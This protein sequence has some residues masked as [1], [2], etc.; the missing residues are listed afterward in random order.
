MLDSLLV[1]FAIFALGFLARGSALIGIDAE[2]PLNDFVYYVSMPCLIM[3]N[4]A[5][6][7]LNAQHVT[8][9]MLNSLAI[10]TSMGLVYALFAAGLV[11]KSF[12]GVL[13]ICIFFGNVIFMGFPVASAYF[14][15]E[16][17]SDAAVIAFAYNVLIFTLG[18]TAIGRIFG[19]D[20]AHFTLG[21]LA[22]NTVLISCVVGAL[23]SF[24]AIPLPAIA[25]QALLMVGET[26]AP[27]ALFAMGAF[28][29]GKKIG[30]RLGEVAGLAFAKMILFPSILLTFGLVMGVTGR[31]LGISFLEA[32]MPIAVTNF[33]IARELSLDAEL[34]AEATVATTLISIPIILLFGQMMIFA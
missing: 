10:L 14:G 22:K 31:P 30:K 13:L 28:I 8:L 3:V 25:S 23:L 29:Y 4:L 15:Q 27:L 20:T 16:A 11:K 7:Q 1:L 32:L 26:T 5:S 21:R 24:F 17:L 12:A 33:V 2:K 34:V 18:I 6:T 19:K 9:I